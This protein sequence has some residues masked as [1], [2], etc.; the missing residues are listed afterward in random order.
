MSDLLQQLQAVNWPVSL[1]IGLVLGIVAHVITHPLQNWVARQSAAR[2]Q[3][4][5]MTL[6]EELRSLE[7][8]TRSSFDFVVSTAVSGFKVVI[9]FVF[10]SAL[11]TL[12]N[13]PAQLF[14]ER[15]MS[16]LLGLVLMG[17]STLMYLVSMLLAV[18]MLWKVTRVRSFNA[19]RQQMERSIAELKET[20]RR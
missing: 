14:P 6:E 1:I 8:M 10:A 4:R 15:M 2:G 11:T 3:R 9:F 18:D 5:A 12:S 19:Q 13:I 7:K 17:V 16:E 20:A